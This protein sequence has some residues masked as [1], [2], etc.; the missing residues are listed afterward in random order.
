MCDAFLPAATREGAGA[1]AYQ[2]MEG[3]ASC[4]GG[5]GVSEGSG[6]VSPAAARGAPRNPWNSVLCRA[7]PP[8][9]G[10]KSSNSHP[11][12]MPGPQLPFSRHTKAHPIPAPRALQ[13]SPPQAPAWP[14]TAP[15][16]GSQQRLDQHTNTTRMF[17]E[18]AQVQRAAGWWWQEKGTAAA[19]LAESKAV[20]P[21]P[22]TARPRAHHIPVL[23]TS[24][25]HSVEEANTLHQIIWFQPVQL[26]SERDIQ[27]RTFPTLPLCIS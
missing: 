13:M 11:G 18:D 23:G 14:S 19:H 24:R 6:R 8:L 5:G 10:L 9:P 20:G 2:V 22:S 27:P 21:P 3:A 26:L 25:G 7:F 12:P 16:P 4:C 1:C 15:F 17:P